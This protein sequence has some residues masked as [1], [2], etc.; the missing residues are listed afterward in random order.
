MNNNVEWKGSL[1]GVVWLPCQAKYAHL[2]KYTR[3]RILEPSIP[4]W[5][6]IDLSG[7]FYKGEPPLKR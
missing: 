7:M 5:E 1:T 3:F 4:V 2:Y 6:I